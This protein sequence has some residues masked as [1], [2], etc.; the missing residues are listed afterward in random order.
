M[1]SAVIFTREATVISSSVCV[2]GEI[3]GESERAFIRRQGV[4]NGT[5]GSARVR[6]LIAGSVDH[7]IE[8]V[9]SL[10]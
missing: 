1:Y 9:G 8:P 3:V 4:D 6:S 5:S 10:L 2:C 7:L